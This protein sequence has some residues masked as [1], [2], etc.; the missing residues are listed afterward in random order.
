MTQ[1]DLNDVNLNDAGECRAFGR[2]LADLLLFSLRSRPLDRQYRELMRTYDESMTLRMVFDGLLEG[3]GAEVIE[4]H[5][6]LGLVVGVTS[7]DSPLLENIRRDSQDADERRVM[8]VVLATPAGALLSRRRPGG[9]DAGAPPGDGTRG[10]R[11]DRPDR[12][13]PAGRGEKAEDRDRSSIW[14][15]VDG[16]MGLERTKND[17]GY[18]KGTVAH[19]ID[20]CFRLLKNR[21]LVTE[22]R[23]V[24]EEAAYRPTLHF[25]SL[26]SNRLNHSLYTEISGGALFPARLF[27][28]GVRTNRHAHDHA[29]RH[30]RCRRSR[31]PVPR[32]RCQPDPPGRGA[33]QG[34]AEAP[35]E[36]RGQDQRDQAVH[37]DLRTRHQADRPGAAEVQGS[38]RR[39]C[40]HR[41]GGNDGRRR[42]RGLFGGLSG[43]PQPRQIVG[44]AGRLRKT[45]TGTD[46]E[47]LYLPLHAHLGGRN[48]Q[49]A[50]RGRRRS[51][52]PDLG[53]QGVASGT[54]R[55][56]PRH[57]T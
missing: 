15:L 7:S 51:A 22:V 20:H 40:R 56:Q 28:P 49:P 1:I 47:R 45:D 42:A 8:A 25:F 36:R 3:L 53:H 12:H 50:H 54:Q 43:G 13:A 5:P 38:V 34:R 55:R 29:H 24:D 16:R 32:L 19:G 4:R 33:R 2:T 17:R 10:P 21:G 6:N 9:P 30:E 23:I 11:E 26:V 46:L 14:E 41:R 57:G 27:G 35:A 18:R 31:C 39:Q 37:R 52:E 44:Y 48:G